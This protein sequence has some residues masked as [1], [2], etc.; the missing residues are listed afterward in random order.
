[1]EAKEICEHMQAKT[2]APKGL[3][4]KKK[5]KEWKEV[6]SDVTGRFNEVLPIQNKSFW[7][8]DFTKQI[9]IHQYKNWMYLK[10]VELKSIKVRSCRPF[11]SPEDLDNLLG[12][13]QDDGAVRVIAG[14]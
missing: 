7:P 6:E 2:Y 11:Y 1:M 3:K 13:R 9:A 8:T 14:E 4:S 10:E 5:E 12:S